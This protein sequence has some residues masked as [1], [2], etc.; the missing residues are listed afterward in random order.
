MK[1]QNIIFIAVLLFLVWKKN[2]KLFILTGLGFFVLSMPLFH[3]W[4]F[5]TAQKLIEYAF[6]FIFIA[7]LMLMFKRH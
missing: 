2:P 6:V 4:I 1:P 3:F 5:F 7:V